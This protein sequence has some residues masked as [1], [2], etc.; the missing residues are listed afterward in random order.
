MTKSLASSTCLYTQFQHCTRS[1]VVV[2]KGQI[3]LQESSPM[4]QLLALRRHP[5]HHFTHFLFECL[6]SAH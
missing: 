1:E 4:L 6:D 3:V 5:T 2:R